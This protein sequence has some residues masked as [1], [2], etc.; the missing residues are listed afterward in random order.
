MSQQAKT[1]GRDDVLFAFHQACERPTADQ[2]IEWT[3][4]YPQFADDIRAHAAV[5]RDWNACEGLPAAEVSETMLDRAYSNALSALYDAE[6]K[7]T[8]SV[9]SASAAQS[10]QDILGQRNKEVYQLAG[11]LDVGRGVLHDLFNGWMLPP[12]RKRLVD[13]VISS[14]AITR[15]AFDSAYALALQN[16]R[17][18]HAKANHA[19]SITQ[20]NCDDIIRDDSMSEKRKC[21]WLEED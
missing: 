14:L 5:S 1:E 19:P 17:L 6:I 3:E 4:R 7:A 8:S 21:Y 9:S 20:R 10:F 16:P 12:V 13:A 18:G 2:I 11:E 15:A